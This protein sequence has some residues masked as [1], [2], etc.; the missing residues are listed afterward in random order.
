MFMAKKKKPCI[1]AAM[2]ML[3]RRDYSIK[4]MR[5]KLAL[6]EYSQEEIDETV[7]RLEDL[8][9]L[10]DKKYAR[11]FVS[12]K[13]RLSGWGRMRIE[14]S[15]R[16][17]KIPEED[18]QAAIEVYEEKMEKNDVPTWT[19]RATE[20]LER[21]YGFFE[22]SLETADFQKRMNFLLRRGYNMDQARQALENT[23]RQED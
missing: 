20:L 4:E 10:D 18:I 5:G 7:A 14:L 2:Y 6:K 11:H 19:A 3:G 1:E 22:G 8:E 13:G 17:K 16:Q 23:R 21:R 12:D 9:Y 15:L